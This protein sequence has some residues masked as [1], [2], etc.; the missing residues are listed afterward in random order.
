MKWNL[1]YCLIFITLLCHYCVDANELKDSSDI[2]S[3]NNDSIFSPIDTTFSF[4]EASAIVKKNKQK[5]QQKADSLSIIGVTAK[6]AALWSLIPGGGQIYNKR[7]WKLPIVYALFAGGAYF[8]A[9]TGRDLRSYNQA[10]D[11]RYSGGTDPYSGIYSDDVLLA[12]RNNA[13]RNFQLSVF[14]TIGIYGLSIMDATVDAHLK[15][16]DIGENLSL[17]IKPKVLT[18]SNNSVPSL[19]IY[20][21]L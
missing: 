3:I 13:R 15:S 18:V 4:K 12:Y 10:L 20:L 8:M 16:F 19:A 17:K 7:Y 1:T 11:I 9:T 5:E 21:Q 14:G 6:K 2:R